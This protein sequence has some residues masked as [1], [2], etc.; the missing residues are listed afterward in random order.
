MKKLLLF[1]FILCIQYTFAQ[2]V[3]ESPEKSPLDLNSITK[4]SVEE[5]KKAGRKSNQIRVK[6]SAPRR[7][8]VRTE[9]KKNANSLST[10]GLA[11]T[12]AKSNLSKSLNL[13]ESLLTISRKLSAEEVRKAAK[14]SVVDK[15]PFFPSC[16]GKKQNKKKQMECF[17]TEMIKH[18]Q[19]HFQYPIEAVKNK[20]QGEVW[21]RFLIDKEGN[22]ANIKTLGPKN[23]E[24][25]NEEAVRVVS[26]LPKFLPALQNGA[27]TPVK[28]GFPI[29]FSLEN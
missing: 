29:S 27:T 21:V 7:R 18:I 25:L 4:C 9:K 11:E 28:Y 17:N 14:F 16:N 13:K 8:F 10:V 23:G 19:K 1:A 2:K 24:I 3:C 20:V 5:T 15:I 26:Q 22:V 6:I 12:E